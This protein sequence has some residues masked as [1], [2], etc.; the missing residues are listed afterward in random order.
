MRKPNV[1]PAVVLAGLVAAL[2]G[3]FAIPG[4]G[5]A[6][7]HTIGWV[8]NLLL[9]ILILV[10]FLSGPWL[11]GG[12]AS[13]AVDDMLWSTFSRRYWHWAF[14]IATSALLLVG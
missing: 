4:S 6:I 5:E 1:L 11:I 14:L 9:T 12:L 3:L 13:M 7:W 10:V 8:G 2:L